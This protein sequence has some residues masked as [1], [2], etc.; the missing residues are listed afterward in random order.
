ME[1]QIRPTS[2]FLDTGYRGLE[3]RT[4]SDA[5]LRKATPNA[6]FEEVPDKSDYSRV[7]TYES[8]AAENTTNSSIFR[9]SLLSIATFFQ[10]NTIALTSFAVVVPML[11]FSITLLILVYAN[12][13]DHT[14]CAHEELCLQQEEDERD[15]YYVQ[16]SATR[17]VFIASWSSTLSLALVCLLMTQ[18][19]FVT[20]KQMLGVA[21]SAH[22]SGINAPTPHQFGLLVKTVN[23]SYSSLWDLF[24]F[25]VLRHK[26][27]ASVARPV[28]GAITVLSTT[29]CVCIMITTADTWLHISTETVEMIQYTGLATEEHQYSRGLAPYCFNRPGSGTFCN[30]AFWTCGLLCRVLD[31]DTL[32][33]GLLVANWTFA[34]SIYGSVSKTHEIIR[35]VRAEDGVNFAIIGPAGLPPTHDYMA[36]T[37]AVASQCTPIRR[38][39]C[40]VREE[41]QEDAH[42]PITFF[43]CTANRSGINVQGAVS[44]L[45]FHRVYFDFSNYLQEPPP[46]YGDQI[47]SADIPGWNES[48]PLIPNMTEE[49]KIYNNPW[50]WM[51]ELA[52][53]PDNPFFGN[54]D[55]HEW[56]SSPGSTSNFMM[57]C[58]ST[59]YDITYSRTNSTNIILHD[60]TPSNSSTTGIITIQ[61]VE[62]LGFATTRLYQ[63]PW[64]INFH[65][66]SL[67]DVVTDYAWGSSKAGAALL[68][69]ASSP[70]PAEKVQ[71]RQTVLVAKVSAGTLWALVVAN[72]LYA[73]VGVVLSVL[74]VR[75]VRGDREGVFQLQTR[76]SVWGLV[77][78]RFEGRYA[79]RQVGSSRGLF[80]ENEGVL[81]GARVVGRRTAGGGAGFV[82]M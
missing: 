4:G 5:D 18:F 19:S 39:A 44:D 82:G 43:N 77:A 10:K 68:A 53:M 70:R 52:L 50:R 6:Y 63:Q 27:R 22:N 78:E 64:H 13:I 60:L 2:G 34:S 41:P 9:Q 8:S 38:T 58:N 16:Y 35:H 73:V 49:S 71:Q 7:E 59:A 33:I 81:S 56:L 45:A 42:Y 14:S 74:A 48:M 61:S 21:P 55:P 40:D 72:L 29:L 12:L 26:N 23:G 11:A 57:S 37:F 31:D 62:T 3:S 47:S 1:N 30:P 32:P 69:A 24:L 15:S 25:H 17:L 75:A 36:K 28:I 67:F 54:N 76:L 20:A 65:T 46:F 79:E 80:K 51:G 66:G